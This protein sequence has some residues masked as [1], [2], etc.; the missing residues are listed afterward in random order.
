L[1]V[2]YDKTTDS[3]RDFDDL[4]AISIFHTSVAMRSLT[5]SAT[6]A[7]SRPKTEACAA[8]AGYSGA[9]IVL[10]Q[11][12]LF[13]LALLAMAQRRHGRLLHTHI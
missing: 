2:L 3:S 10:L 11:A 9:T 4:P 7:V 8:K 12:C 6:S 1:S 13:G 5:L